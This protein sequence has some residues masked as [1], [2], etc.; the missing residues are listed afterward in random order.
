[1]RFANFLKDVVDGKKKNEQQSF[2]V[3]IKVK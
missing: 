3:D 2:S 1:M